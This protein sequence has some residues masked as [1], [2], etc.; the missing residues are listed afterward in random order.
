MAKFEF[1]N[2]DCVLEIAEHEYTVTCNS[3]MAD[4]LIELG[5][6]QTALFEDFEAG[7]ISKDDVLKKY[8]EQID[9]LLGAGESELLL[10]NSKSK[11]NDAAD[12]LMFISGELT[13]WFKAH[14]NR[15]TRRAAARSKNGR[16]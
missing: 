7:R 9:C 3:D 12:I 15:A 4:R 11:F 14:S 16:K 6:Q 13:G 5:Q 1:K 2:R 10:K 8:C